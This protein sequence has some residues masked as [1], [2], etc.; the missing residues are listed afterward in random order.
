MSVGQTRS[1]QIAVGLQLPHPR[2]NSNFELSDGHYFPL[3]V[4]LAHLLVFLGLEC[5]YGMQAEC[6]MVSIANI[7]APLYAEL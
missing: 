6:D 5:N 2:L 3:I 4:G 1:P 7:L